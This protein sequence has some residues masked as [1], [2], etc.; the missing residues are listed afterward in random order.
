MSI[1]AKDDVRVR[2]IEAAAGLLHD[3]GAQAVTT[4]AVAQLA[5]V[6]APA[7]YRLFGDKDGLVD[8]VAEHVMTQWV[9]DKTAAA[10]RE[11]PDP[12][13][14]LRAG[15]VMQIEFG[16]ANPELYALLN[17]P[18]RRHRSPA[19]SAGIEILRRRVHRLAAD[20]HLR[21]SEQRAVEMIHAAGSGAVLTLLSTPIDQRDPG[22]ADAM[23]EA[24]VAGITT[25]APAAPASDRL[26]IAVGFATVVPDLPALRDTERALL[27]DWVDR[28]I[29]HLQRGPEPEGY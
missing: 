6:Q 4:R 27:A 10:A 26:T 11:D 22:L 29:Q 17:A 14:A 19:T 18:E 13:T 28:A 8:A 12:L 3:G 20:G 21:V 23:Y 16:L 25:T 1:A 9:A 7:I 15:W 2:V 24:V 5:G